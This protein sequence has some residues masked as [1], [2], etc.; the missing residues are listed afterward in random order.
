MVSPIL[1]GITLFARVLQML[2]KK[3]L[4]NYRRCMRYRR[5]NRERYNAYMRDYRRKKKPVDTSRVLL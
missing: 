4:G 2:S 3:Q 1:S 5:K